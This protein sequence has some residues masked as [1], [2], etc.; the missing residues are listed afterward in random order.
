MFLLV[1][2]PVLLWI[3]ASVAAVVLASGCASNVGGPAATDGATDHA[4]LASTVTDAAVFPPRVEVP[5]GAK[6]E[7]VCGRNDGDV[8]AALV[9]YAA[10]QGKTV[11][12]H[13][14]GDTSKWDHPNYVYTCRFCNLDGMNISVGQTQHIRIENSSMKGTT[15]WGQPTGKVTLVNVYGRDATFKGGHTLDATNADLR[16]SKEIDGWAHFWRTTSAKDV[17]WSGSTSSKWFT[18]P[19]SNVRFTGTTGGIDFSST[20]LDG[21]RFDGTTSDITMDQM[22]VS[23]DVRFDGAG[24]FSLTATDTTFAGGSI[25]SKGAGGYLKLAGKTTFDGVDLS[26]NDGGL[27][28]F[29]DNGMPAIAA[30]NGTKW[31]VGKN[32]LVDDA[33]LAAI[34]FGPDPAKPS[35]QGAALV[36][37]NGEVWP[38][39]KTDLTGLRLTHGAL[40]IGADLT[41]V[42][43]DKARLERVDFSNVK[44]AQ[45]VANEHASFQHAVLQNA[46]FG[47]A[48]IEGVDFTNAD[49]RGASFAMAKGS[50]T[51]VLATAGV[52]PPHVGDN[53]GDNAKSTSFLR[54]V[55]GT[56]SFEHAQLQY[57]NLGQA[58]LADVRF[59]GA[60]LDWAKLVG[61]HLYRKTNG[62]NGVSNTTFAAAAS[63]HGI[64]LDGADLR[65]VSLA[66]LDFSPAADGGKEPARSSF[67]GA[68]MCGAALTGTN[69]RGADL[70][71]AYADVDGNIRLPDGVDGPCKGGDR[72]R[73]D[74]SSFS[75]AI[76]T[77]CPVGGHAPAG[78]DGKCTD[79]QWMQQGESSCTAEQTANALE[80]GGPCTID[81]D[82]QSLFC[83]VA[84]KVGPKGTC[85]EPQK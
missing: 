43:L 14:S 38:T 17:D 47:N 76:A 32:H 65:G 51:F 13:P 54:A 82:C 31:P 4:A 77:R 61:A 10:S 29:F 55:L 12:E 81:C 11:N 6:Q 59:I 39:S 28:I 34:D 15:I 42:T 49:L 1:N 25:R 30:R 75:S 67:A 79:A 16:C 7:Q 64:V 85:Q 56:S 5:F 50:A 22:K 44:L 41:K 58:E 48:S 53:D 21:A 73:V 57:A 33:H 80:D 69:L 52:L 46:D 63:V 84:G 78:S 68:F 70:T 62:G 2:R 20:T 36:T 45:G 66:N 74:T 3:A 27:R 8:H 26:E 9:A 19:A 37:T 72:A 18:G 23:G 83:D 71:G 24:W 35:G 40:P 60:T